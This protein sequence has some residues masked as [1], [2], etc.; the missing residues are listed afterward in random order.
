MPGRI[1]S[2]TVAG[3]YAN[4]FCGVSLTEGEDIMSNAT[5]SK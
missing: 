1:Y 2:A 3:N 4:K 5:A